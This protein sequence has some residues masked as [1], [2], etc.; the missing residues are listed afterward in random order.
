MRFLHTSDWHLGLHIRHAAQAAS[1]LRE[2]RWAAV[3][4]VAGIAREQAVDFVVIAGDV[5]DSNAPPP[6]EIRE[7][8]A[9]L[10]AFPAPVYLIPGNHDPDVPGGPWEHPSWS[11][12]PNVTLLLR[13]EAIPVNGC[14]LYPCPLRSRWQG[15]QPLDWIPPR[16]P[17]DGIRL[18]L[19]HGGL[20]TSGGSIPVDAALRYD[21]DYLALG[22]WHSSSPDLQPGVR[23]AYSGT[24]ETDAFG[25]R[26]SGLVL[27]VEI[28]GPLDRPRI[29]RHRSGRLEWRQRTV[30]FVHEGD[31]T[32]L[33]EELEADASPD[34]LLHLEVSGS[35]FPGDEREL[36]AIAT[37]LQHG[38]F[39]GR[40]T[41]GPF[42]PAGQVAAIP[43]GFPALAAERLRTRAEAGDESA[44]RALLLLQRLAGEAVT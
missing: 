5:F 4:R 15:H 31:A 14:T 26:E 3:G 1:R 21:L 25:Q 38:Y 35:L 24:P 33:R 17:E 23:Q 20:A 34:V 27:V 2:E 32:R 41:R 10:E 7:A 42:W 29:S 37:L 43:A 44:A 40:L 16:R 19:A 11:E 12:S 39:H 18:G 30:R 6:A 36:A 28:E 13:T 22:D 8:A 9:L